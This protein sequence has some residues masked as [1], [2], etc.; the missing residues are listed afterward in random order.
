LLNNRRKSRTTK[1]TQT[2]VSLIQAHLTTVLNQYCPTKPLLLVGF[3]GGIDSVVL[4]HALIQLQRSHENTL[5]AFSLHAMHVHHGLSAHADEWA[6][7][8]KQFCAKYQIPFAMRQVYVNKE[9]PLGIEAAA[10]EARY[11]ALFNYQFLGQSANFILTGHHQNDQA[12]TLMLQLLRGAGLK[13]MAG[14]AEVDQGK[15]LLRPFLAIAKPTILDYANRE[16]LNWCED[17]SNTNTDFDRNFLRQTVIPQ[18]ETRYPAMQSVL[19]RTAIHI[20]ESQDLLNDLAELDASQLIDD[21]SVCLIGLAELS[22][23]RARNLLRWWFAENDLKMPSADSLSEIMSQLLGA[24]IDARVKIKVQHLL[25]QRFQ[26]RAF[27]NTEKPAQAFDLLWSG[28][29]ELILPDGSK[30]VFTQVKGEGLAIKHGMERLRVTNRKGGERFKPEAN[31]PSRTLK[32]LLQEVSIS[33]WRRENMPLIYWNDSLAYVPVVGAV[34]DL[35]ASAEEEGIS[36][37]WVAA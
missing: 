6:Q 7:F 32:Y 33:P 29:P 8:C 12:E 35:K 5:Q 27:L 3:S 13:G 24:K 18:I 11:E 2:S 31:R 30:L 16:K 21:N 22:P 9:S 19:A 10:R 17:D 34:F 36:I 23:A 4:L 37:S 1:E 26:K 25:L 20:A 15:R 14:M 28:E